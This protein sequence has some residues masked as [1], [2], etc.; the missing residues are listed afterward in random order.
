MRRVGLDKQSVWIL[1]SRSIDL[2]S[3]LS[4]AKDASIRRASSIPGYNGNY[5]TRARHHHR[6]NIFVQTTPFTRSSQCDPFQPRIDPFRDVPLKTARMPS[7]YR[8]IEKIKRNHVA[9]SAQSL[10]KENGRMRVA[11]STSIREVV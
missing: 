9:P 10:G 2:D 7:S 5:E 8:R 3:I 11:A 1:N 6:C 4:P